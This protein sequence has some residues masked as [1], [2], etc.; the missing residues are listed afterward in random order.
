MSG[1]HEKFRVLE[2]ENSS[3]R[4]FDANGIRKTEQSAGCLFAVPHRPYRYSLFKKS[5]TQAFFA[6]L[7]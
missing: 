3:T 6:R 4:N 2:I 5:A 1:K 7:L